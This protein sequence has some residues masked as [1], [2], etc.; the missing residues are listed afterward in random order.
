MPRYYFD[1]KNGRRMVDSVGSNC[2]DDIGAIA[3]A[4]FMATQIAIDTPQNHERHIAVLNAAG[5][6]IFKTPVRMKT[7]A[8]SK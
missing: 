5:D 7:S 8:C 1:V 6:E 2:A 4:K 3:T